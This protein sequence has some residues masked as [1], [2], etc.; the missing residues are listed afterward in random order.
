[1]ITRRRWMISSLLLLGLLG[2]GFYIWDEILKPRWIP[3]RFAVVVPDRLYRSGQLSRHL[4]ESTLEKWDIDLV[5]DL[6]GIVEG[7]LDQKAELDAVEK[8]GI[9][10]QRCGLAGDGRGDI[11]SYIRALSLIHEG[12]KNDRKILVHCTA[13]S[14]RTGGVIAMYRVL[15]EGASLEDAVEEMK[16][17]GW[18]PPRDEIL[19]RYLNEKMDQLLA[20]LRQQ[21]IEPAIDDVPQ[22]QVSQSLDDERKPQ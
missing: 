16:R 9:E 7:D 17:H 10:H 1:M 21:E 2:A 14:Q 12:L 22:F 15:F 13:G 8:L 18:R 6:N 5:I 11:N 19:L 20:G 3:K 4:V